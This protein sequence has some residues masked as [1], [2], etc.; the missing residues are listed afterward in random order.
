MIRGGAVVVNTRDVESA[1]RFYI[2]TLGMKLV[3][4]RSDGSAL[5]DAGEGFGIELR[6]GQAPSS[7]VVLYPKVP[8][9]EAIAIY[10]NRGVTFSVERTE[11]TVV[12]R[13][14]D[15]DHNELALVQERSRP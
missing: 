1:L 9:D 3:E 14:H 8:I 7:S 6:K 10:E 13:F 2:E 15:L 11:A 5:L 4:Q 12:A